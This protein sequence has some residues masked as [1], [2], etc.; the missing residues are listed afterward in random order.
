MLV[1]ARPL[2]VIDPLVPLQVVGL[3][4]VV[5]VITGTGFTVAVVVPAADVQPATVAVTE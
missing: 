4:E 5:L 3:V 2:R 1:F